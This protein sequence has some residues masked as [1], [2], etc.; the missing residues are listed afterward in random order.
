MGLCRNLET[1]SA[2]PFLVPLMV[3]EG[4]MRRWFKTSELSHWA[5]IKLFE[6]VVAFV[7]DE[8]EGREILHADFPNGLHTE[9]RVFKDFEFL[10]VIG[11]E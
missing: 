8:D 7:I 9:F 1:K 6:E 10:D 5:L 2:E 3:L 4:C 11:G